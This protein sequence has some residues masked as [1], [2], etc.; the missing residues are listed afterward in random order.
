MKKAREQLNRAL[1]EHLNTIHETFQIFDR[2]PAASLEKVSWKEV[3]Q[4]SERVSKQATTVGML[5]AGDSPG[6]KALEEN[7]AAYFNILQGFLLLSHGS[8][9]GAGPT[10]SSCIHTSVKQVVDSSFMLFQ[11]AVSSYAGSSINVQ[12]LSIPQLVGTVWDACSA[13][14]KTPATNVTAIGRSMTQVAVS[15]KDAL[16]EMKELKPADESTIPVPANTDDKSNNEDDSDEELGNDLSPEEMKIVQLTT[17]IVSEALLVIKELIR[18]ITGLLKKEN[19]N[20]V[21]ISVDSLEILLRLSQAI[22]VEVDDLGACLYPPQEI[23]AIKMALG[24]ISSITNE[25]EME[26]RNL[27]GS[28]EDFGK[29]CA[30]LR[31]SL[32]E[33]E[34][35]LGCVGA[36]DIV[37]EMENLVVS[38]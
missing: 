34:T 22:G 28:S 14:K 6:V 1:S 5:Y 27:E 25:T 18:S 23:S 3:I 36:R 21:A 38:K 10:L 26:L 37:Q 12:K 13:L 8:S 31:G 2:A 9:L 7:M 4:M 30:G 19:S 32:R 17:C 11:G 15:M 35:V 29:A 33:L 16:R 24:K 20:D